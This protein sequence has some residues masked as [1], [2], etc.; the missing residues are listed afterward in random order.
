MTNTCIQ[1]PLKKKTIP[2]CDSHG[3]EGI[4]PSRGSGFLLAL[5]C[6]NVQDTILLFIVLLN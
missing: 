3:E 4:L 5:S 1:G 2:Q 6:V